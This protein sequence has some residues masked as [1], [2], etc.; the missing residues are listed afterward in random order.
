MCGNRS[1]FSLNLNENFRNL[2]AALS[3]AGRQQEE[4]MSIK[5]SEFENLHRY[6]IV[7]TVI[8]KHSLFGYHRFP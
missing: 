6:G 8:D 1:S 7:F 5:I 4:E 3:E 2:K